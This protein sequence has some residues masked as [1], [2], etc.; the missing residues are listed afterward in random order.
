MR[1]GRCGRPLRRRPRT[2]DEAALVTLAADREPNVR[3]A[4]LNGLVRLKSGAVQAAV[5]ALKLD[6]Y[7]LIER[8][9]PC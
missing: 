2:L 8:P 9:P 3:D 1:S 6:D 5:D 7:Q 4:A